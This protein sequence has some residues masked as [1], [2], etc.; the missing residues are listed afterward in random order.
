[1]NP[2]AHESCDKFGGPGMLDGPAHEG[3][4]Q[5]PS[6]VHE[7][8]GIHLLFEPLQVLGALPPIDSENFSG[9]I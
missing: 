7:A 1:M 6:R 9:K 4:I 3:S 8:L 5:N 2:I